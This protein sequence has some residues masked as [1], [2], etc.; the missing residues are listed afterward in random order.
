MKLFRSLVIWLQAPLPRTGGPL[1]FRKRVPAIHVRTDV[2]D[3]SITTADR[4]F[5]GKPR[6]SR[7]GFYYHEMALDWQGTRYRLYW[8]DKTRKYAFRP[9]Q[10]WT[11]FVDPDDLSSVWCDSAEARIEPW[12]RAYPPDEDAGVEA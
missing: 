2:Y 4:L 9:G 11:V 6:Q 7:P 10:A 3:A 1:R 12:N 8:L 5:A